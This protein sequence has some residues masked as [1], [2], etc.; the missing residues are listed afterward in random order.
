MMLGR[1][2]VQQENN[3]KKKPT[4]KPKSTTTNDPT[5]TIIPTTTVLL[6]LLKY[7]SG[8]EKRQTHL[9]KELGGWL[10]KLFGEDIRSLSLVTHIYL[11]WICVY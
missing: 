3:T 1:L 2:K 7:R 8:L 9:F 5:K 11:L 4:A 10:H 6:D